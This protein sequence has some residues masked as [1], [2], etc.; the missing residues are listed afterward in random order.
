MEEKIREALDSE[1][2]RA[3]A[4]SEAAGAV[5]LLRDR[6][7]ENEVA[8]AQFMLVFDAQIFDADAPKWWLDLAQLDRAEFEKEALL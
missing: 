6:L 5:P 1:K 2:S 3:G 8:L 7:H 4:I